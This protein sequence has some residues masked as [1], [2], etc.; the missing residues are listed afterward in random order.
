MEPQYKR[1][2]IWVD[3]PFQTRLL[4]RMVVYLFLFFFVA[5]HVAFFFHVLRHFTTN[6]LG[7]GI[8]NLYLD[9]LSA[10][11]PL[12]LTLLMLTPILLYDLLKF[13]HRVAG[14]LF[15][16]RKILGEMADGKPVRPFTPRQGD[17]MRELIAAF[18]TLIV[19]WNEKHELIAPPTDSTVAPAAVPAPACAADAPCGAPATTA[20]IPAEPG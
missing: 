13:S 2:R 20:A 4:V 8:D 9:F 10:Q 1:K 15:R 7:A 3:P 12:L 5:L 17:L 16:A 6:G 18:N 11:Q 14:P 19:K